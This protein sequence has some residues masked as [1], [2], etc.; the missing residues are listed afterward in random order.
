[1]A[2]FMVPGT[3]NPGTETGT[4]TETET[5]TETYLDSNLM[6]YYDQAHSTAT[7]SIGEV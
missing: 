7:E 6:E 5:G 4:E 3:I 2:A 1:M